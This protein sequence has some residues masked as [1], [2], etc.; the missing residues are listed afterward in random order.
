MSMN[1]HEVFAVFFTLLLS[2]AN[3]LSRRAHGGGNGRAGVARAEAL[4]ATALQALEMLREERL[5]ANRSAA[6]N[7]YAERI[8]EAETAALVAAN[9]E[10]RLILDA[11]QKRCEELNARIGELERD[12]A[13]ERQSFQRR[14]A[15][16]EASVATAHMTI[17]R[18]Q[19]ELATA[20][21]RAAELATKLDSA[22][23]LIAALRGNDV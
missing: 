16:L 14:I 7:S 20:N 13:A 19:E 12:W 1:W 9:N 11:Q 6:A 4:G 21:N 15:L 2:L 5:K 17:K 10:L 8:A 23:R 3:F 22:E 18:L